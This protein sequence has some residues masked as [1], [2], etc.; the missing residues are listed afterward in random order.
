MH[1]EI[2][3]PR[4]GI[5]LLTVAAV[6]GWAMVLLPAS[7]PA[8]PT[9]VEAPTAQVLSPVAQG[10]SAGVE[11]AMEEVGRAQVHDEQHVHSV[12]Q[13]IETPTG[14]SQA[15]MRLRWA[16]SEQAFLQQK[17]NIVREQLRSL[18]QQREALG[19]VVDPEIEDQFRR[20]V[21]TLTALMKDQQQAEQFLL[22]AFRQ[23]WEAEERAMALATGE[24]SGTI[25]LLWPVEPALG[26]SAGFMD[27]GYK[28]RFKVDHYA[29]DIPVEQGTDVFA[30]H[31]G[32]IEDVVDHGLGYN[33]VTLS[34]GG[35]ATVY[36]HLSEFAVRPGQR[37]RAGDRIGR[38]G[39]MPGLPGGGS[40]TG[41]HLHFGLYVKGSPVDPT[42]YLP[43]SRG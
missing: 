37:V 20:S 42:P 34:G 23:M 8:A 18:Q 43:E 39:G 21:Q 7:T 14:M 29:I 31:D 19:P 30:A 36:G 22:L 41:P 5:T 11:R 6:S 26:I 28:K 24:Q 38:S 3:I 17:E 4:P 35:Y 40:S 9:V 32:L 15:E 12:A 13:E 33:Y 27:E 1:I 2:S 16:R 10:P 25:S